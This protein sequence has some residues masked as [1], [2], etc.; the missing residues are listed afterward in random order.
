MCD[1]A[2]CA[3]ARAVAFDQAQERFAAI[4]HFERVAAA[5]VAAET[6]SLGGLFG[7]LHET[8]KS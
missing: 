1:C 4:A 8:H 6:L 5:V 3:R 2:T 7:L